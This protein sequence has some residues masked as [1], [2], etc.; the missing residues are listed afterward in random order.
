MVSHVDFNVS[1][2]TYFLRSVPV[3]S[4]FCLSTKLIEGFKTYTKPFNMVV[5]C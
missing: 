2:H 5:D 1:I 4:V 3:A